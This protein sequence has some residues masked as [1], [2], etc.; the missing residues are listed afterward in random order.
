M[1]RRK[2]NKLGDVTS[3]ICA[4]TKVVISLMR[5]LFCLQYIVSNLP[6]DIEQLIKNNEE[7]WLAL[8]VSSM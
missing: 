8:E 7:K 5:V 3:H 1:C 6:A 4:Q 2:E